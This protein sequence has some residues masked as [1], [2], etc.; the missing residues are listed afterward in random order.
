MRFRSIAAMA[1]LL[2]FPICASASCG[3]ASCP[4]DL[5]SLDRPHEGGFSLDL[6]FE[7]IDQDQLRGHSDIVPDHTE[8]RTINRT[9]T[10]VLR[11]A[12]KE[13]LQLSMTTPYIARSHQHLH[14]DELESWQLDGAGDVQLQ[15]RGRVAPHVWL[16]GGVKLPTGVD[17]VRNDDGERAE[18]TIQPGSGSTDLIAGAA[19]EGGLLRQ[20]HVQGSMGNTAVIPYFA[21][22]TYRRNGRGT[23]DHRVGNELQLNAGT[24]Y[25]LSEHIEALLQ[26]NARRRGRDESPDDPQDAFFTGGTFV[27]LSPG[28]RWSAGRGALYALVQVP[29]MQHVNGIQLTAERNWIGGMQLRF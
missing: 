12:P 3:S 1:V 26:A 20:T 13:W 11:Y 23:L 27:Y 16:I 14:D 17:D 7:Y 19:Y 4:L 21:S 10:M 29:V 2:L 6:S 5:N 15:A 8:V 28:L 22:V 9:A 24:A 25:P 18:T